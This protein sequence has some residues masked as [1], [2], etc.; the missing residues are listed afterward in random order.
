MTRAERNLVVF[1][2]ALVAAFTIEHIFLEV[3][4]EFASPATL[5]P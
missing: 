3:R 5:K 2:C 4:A 1:L